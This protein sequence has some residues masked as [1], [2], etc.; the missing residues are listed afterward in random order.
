M[1]QLICPDC[2]NTMTVYDLYDIFCPKAGMS[3]ILEQQICVQCA[4]SAMQVVN[5]IDPAVPSSVVGRR[6]SLQL[7]C[8]VREPKKF[9]S[10]Q[11]LTLFKLYYSNFI[12]GICASAFGAVWVKGFEL[13]L[14]DAVNG[15]STALVLNE[16]ELSKLIS[17]YTCAHLWLINPNDWITQKGGPTTVFV[18]AEEWSLLYKNK[19]KHL[20]KKHGTS[21]RTNVGK[22]P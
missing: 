8:D 5:V 11:L 9:T 2:L 13:M 12:H 20:E 16:D 10:A 7:T 14:W 17:L 4:N 19:K 1:A 15:R 21:Q 6:E 3:V 18:T 22:T